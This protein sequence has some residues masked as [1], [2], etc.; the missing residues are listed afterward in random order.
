MRPSSRTRAR[1]RGCAAGSAIFHGAMVHERP[2]STRASIARPPSPARP[3]GPSRGACA[4]AAVKWSPRRAS[5][6]P[7]PRVRLRTASSNAPAPGVPRWPKGSARGRP[8]SPHEPP[9]QDVITARADGPWR[10]ADVTLRDGSPVR[11]RPV[12]AADGALLR[13][14]F[15]RLSPQSRYRR[16][17]T[18]MPRLD[19]AL[20]RYLTVVDH[21]DHEAPI[22]LSGEGNGIGV[23]RFFRSTD[24]PNVADAAVTVVDDWQARGLGTALLAL[25]NGRARDEGITCFT[26]LMLADNR[27]MRELLEALGHVR[28]LE[29]RRRPTAAAGCLAR[30]PTATT[31]G[32]SGPQTPSRS[33]Q[34]PSPGTSWSSPGGRR[35]RPRST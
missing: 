14:G 28:L 24:H 18:P 27:A 26:A 3:R 33:A 5:S 35:G 25:L 10:G 22:A 15:E 8:G 6:S 30:R 17:M 31:R 21:H 29:R 13:A 9:S 1:T 11:V 7:T 19:D 16:F 32:L 2:P 34:R 4:A 12:Q 20:V 23:A